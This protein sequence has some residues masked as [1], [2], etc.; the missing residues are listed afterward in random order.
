MFPPPFQ[1]EFDIF[2]IHL[3]FTKYQQ[4]LVN[5]LLCRF[6]GVGHHLKNVQVPIYINYVNKEILSFK[7]WMQMMIKLQEHKK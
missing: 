6:V 3:M 2:Y 1:R 4:F 7:Q 5:K